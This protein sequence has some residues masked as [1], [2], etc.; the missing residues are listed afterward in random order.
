MVFASGER[1]LA[2]TTIVTWVGDDFEH[3]AAC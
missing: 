3:T 1:F 2:Q